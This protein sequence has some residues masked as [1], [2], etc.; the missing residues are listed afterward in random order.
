MEK[1]KVLEFLLKNNID[2]LKLGTV[3]FL[4]A[5]NLLCLT[6]LYK[7]NE[8]TK[9]EENKT[10]IESLIKE[11]V[12]IKNLNYQI[13]YV[14]A[15]LDC[16]R[17]KLYI[18]NFLKTNHHLTYFALKNIVVL[19][20]GNNF[21]IS[22]SFSLTSEECEKIC[23]EIY[24][25]LE[26]RFFYNFKITYNIVASEV[27]ELEDHKT[28]ILDNLSAPILIN[29]IKVNK[30]EN[31]IGEITENTCYPFEFYKNPEEN[32]I[33]CGNLVSIN[34]IE[35]T[36]KDGE[37]KGVRYALK[38]KCLDKTFDASLFPIKK[39]LELIKTIE[40]GIDIIVSGS[41]DS[42]N[43]GLSLKVKNLAKCEILHY[44]KPKHELNKEFKNYRFVIP[45]KYE[46]VSQI[47]LFEENVKKDYL[48]NNEFVVFDIETTGLD[49][50][51]HT[52]T[53]IGAVKIKNGKIIETFSTLINPEQE[54]SSEIT[55]ITGITQEMVKDAPKLNDIIP[56]FF[57]FC[58]NSILVGQNVQ[59][60]FG[61]IDYYSRQI[62]YVFDHEKD[63]TMII[64]KKHMFLKNYKLKTIAESLN[65]PLINAHRAINDALATAKVFI[66]LIEKFY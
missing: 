7:E 23:K 13:K 37:T 31:I 29:K 51:T 26:S 58:K 48:M 43:N 21:N 3:T 10:K 64:A 59:F 65:V 28:E 36:K 57:K 53:E 32:V 9:I 61:F 50:M 16:D 40:A 33:L 25:F 19:N 41:L 46:E 35:Y 52:L 20:E 24:Y 15:F 60:D 8:I 27:D 44:E 30:I 18:E 6:F 62:N 38:I 12:N 34:E 54:I 47:N 17:A 11:Y 55:K 49:Y 14:K 66:K 63:D 4:K 2:F 1:E 45:Q 56:D 5:E 22:L 42:F 39:N